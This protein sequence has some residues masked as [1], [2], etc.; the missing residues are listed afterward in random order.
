[1][2]MAVITKQIEPVKS[3]LQ[4]GKVVAIP[5]E[6][7]YG[8]AGNAYSRDT[9][10]QIFDIKKRP[11]SSP[12]IIHTDS[13][14]KVSGMVK[15]ISER[16][17]LLAQV[18]WPGP[19]TLILPKRDHIS[20]EVTAGRPDVAIRVP[21][22]PLTLQLLRSLDFPLV[23]TSANV[24]G[25]ISPTQP[26]HVALHLGEEIGYI[27]DGGVCS[28][29]L[30][31]TIVDCQGEQ[32]TLRRV[33]A[34]PQA[35]IEAVIGPVH[36]ISDHHTN[37]E[38]LS[39]S[40]PYRLLGKLFIVGDLKEL[41]EQYRYDYNLGILAFR[42]YD[43]R[44]AKEHQFVLSPRGLL[45]QAASNL[46]KGLHYLEQLPVDMILAEYLPDQGIGK[47]VNDRL[48]RCATRKNGLS[49]G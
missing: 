44:I 40:S 39:D 8:L 5:T 37:Q 35:Q 26:E 47:T 12:L 48:S 14:D 30:E 34:I 31:S 17:M 42:K 43:R 3:A 27:L 16:A 24:F 22:H 9:V 36:G 49:V 6:T 18:F 25:Q 19:L 10:L 33:G 13:L 41:V 32:A 23:A 46:F 7:V 28:I 4:Q 15:H 45:P 21:S 1:M 38:P 29:G 2:R 20:H 11:L